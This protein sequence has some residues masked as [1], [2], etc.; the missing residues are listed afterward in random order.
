MQLV[1][2]K[3]QSILRCFFTKKSLGSYGKLGFCFSVSLFSFL[4]YTPS[5][6]QLATRAASKRTIADKS[7]FCSSLQMNKALSLTPPFSNPSK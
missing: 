7:T 4:A 1:N 6:M 3:S 5:C 2:M